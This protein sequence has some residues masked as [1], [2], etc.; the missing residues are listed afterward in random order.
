LFEE[1]DDIAEASS[2]CYS[3]TFTLV[4]AFYSAYRHDTCESDSLSV[5]L[6]LDDLLG[7][8][9]VVGLV[10]VLSELV[11]CCAV[12]VG[13]RD[14]GVDQGGQLPD[15]TEDTSSG[16]DSAVALLLWGG[17][18][19]SQEG[20]FGLAARHCCGGCCCSSG[21]YGELNVDWYLDGIYAWE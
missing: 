21:E 11:W 7:S 16:A 6:S 5:E 19:T 2:V 12:S 3:E 17:S 10:G 20:L 13:E 14:V 4:G 8:G 18:E 15:I 1:G 9:V